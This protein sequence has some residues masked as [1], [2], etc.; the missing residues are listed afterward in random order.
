MRLARLL[1][2]PAIL[3]EALWPNFFWLTLSRVKLC[4]QCTRPS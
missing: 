4:F 2:E 3:L 1:R